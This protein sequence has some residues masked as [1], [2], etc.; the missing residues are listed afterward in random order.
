[1]KTVAS[2]WGDVTK[3][4]QMDEQHCHRLDAGKDHERVAEELRFLRALALAVGECE[5]V[6]SALDVVLHGVCEVTGW[7][8]GQAW[9]P[10]ARGTALECGS[11]YYSCAHGLDAFR[12]ASEGL[13]LL[14]G[15]G[16]PGRA[17][18]TREPVWSRDVTED[19]RVV[20]ADVA[21][22]VGLKAGMAIPVLA[23]Q[24]VVA[25]LEFFVCDQREEDDRLVALVSAV[26][27]QLGTVIRHKQAE[28][29]LH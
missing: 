29:A 8:V 6:A 11:A 12:R 13:V 9:M 16:L 15:T 28:D 14:P 27:A 19:S 18:A 17:W 1:M 10:D 2:N 7:T 26:A 5:D 25:V 3:R 22:Q 21:R 23:G 24:D 20:Q 4:R